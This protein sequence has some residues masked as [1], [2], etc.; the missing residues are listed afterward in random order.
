L[1]QDFERQLQE[2]GSSDGGFTVEPPELTEVDALAQ[3]IQVEAEFL[4]AH[5]NLARSMVEGVR[6]VDR[7]VKLATGN[8]VDLKVLLP[9]GLAVY[10]FLEAG[11]EVATPLWVTLGIFSFN[12]FV[13]LHT[14]HSG[15]APT[16][17][18][19]LVVNP[20]EPRKNR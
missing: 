11:V 16:V 10:S 5:S 14:H 12:S 18:E 9:L 17:R 20:P 13:V 19:E 4:S 1:H 2:R 7:A 3:K 15:R 6:S 8:T